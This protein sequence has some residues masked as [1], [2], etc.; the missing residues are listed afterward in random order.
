MSSQ[1]CSSSHAGEQTGLWNGWNN[2]GRGIANVGTPFAVFAR[3]PLRCVAAMWGWA[4]LGKR[5][6]P[7]PRVLQPSRLRDG[8][9][10][11]IPTIVE[12]GLCRTTACM[13]NDSLAPSY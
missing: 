12:E 4:V 7:K 8:C 1:W 6:G 10:I 13:C 3:A 2:H 9:S 11:E 5:G